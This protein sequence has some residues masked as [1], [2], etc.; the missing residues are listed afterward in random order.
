MWRSIIFWAVPPT[1][2]T[3]PFQDFVNKPGN[4]DLLGR[5]KFNFEFNK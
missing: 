3:R 1:I 2:Y 5:V 4:N